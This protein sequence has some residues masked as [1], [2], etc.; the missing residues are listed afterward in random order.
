MKRLIICVS[1]IVV[2]LS[3]NTAVSADLG[4]SVVEAA[5]PIAIGV[6]GGWQ[7]V[8]A[9]YLWAAGL[10]GDVGVGG[11]TAQIDQSF[12]DILS[13]L[14][15]GFMGVTEVRYDRFGVFSDLTYA[16]LS[17]TDKTESGGAKTY[18]GSGGI[19]PLR[20]V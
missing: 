15:I 20:A 14:D 18:H 2:P 1:A 6:P 3:V 17:A 12:G 13:D 16:K 7:V 9:P 8:V 10:S 19:V 11:R 5:P 4:T